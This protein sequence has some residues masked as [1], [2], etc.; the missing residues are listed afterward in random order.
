MKNLIVVLGILLLAGTLSAQAPQSFKYQAIA[1]DVEGNIISDQQISFRIN[2]L[3]D[4]ENGTTVYSEIHDLRT[5]LFGLINLEIGNGKEKTG[6]FSAIQ[7]KSGKYFVNVEI[8]VNGGTDFVSMGISQLLSV[9]YALYAETSGTSAS[10]STGSKEANS[11]TDGES[12]T[13]LTNSGWNVGIGTSAPSSKLDVT[14]KG[15]FENV[16]GS[17][18]DVTTAGGHLVSNKFEVLYEPASSSAV[19]GSSLQIKAVTADPAITDFTS[20]LQG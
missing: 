12:V 8:D 18:T 15:T 5:N 17:K 19:K 14:G 11:W 9:P 7:W 3:K 10:L 2:L 16:Y 13:Y 1:R 20:F 6:D 4:N